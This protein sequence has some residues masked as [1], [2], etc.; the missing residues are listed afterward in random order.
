MS[1]KISDVLHSLCSFLDF[2]GKGLF[3]DLFHWLFQLVR[4]LFNS[5]SYTNQV[6]QIYFLCES[7]IFLGAVIHFILVDPYH[8]LLMCWPIS[9]FSKLYSYQTN[10]LNV[11]NISFS[12]HWLWEKSSICESLSHNYEIKLI[13]WSVNWD[14][15]MSVFFFCGFGTLFFM[16]P[17]PLDE[18]FAKVI[19]MSKF[20]RI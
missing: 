20:V 8:L 4:L 3:T 10:N 5:V 17:T 7:R 11:I 13:K 1:S 18:T 6:L 12:R 9:I 16:L 14:F 19:Y 15:L 2:Y